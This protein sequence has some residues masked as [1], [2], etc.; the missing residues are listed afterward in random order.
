MRRVARAILA[1]LPFGMTGGM[2]AAFL[3]YF[4][5]AAPLVE[6]SAAQINAQ[7]TRAMAREVTL[8]WLLPR[9]ENAKMEQ[10]LIQMDVLLGLARDHGVDLPDTMQ[11]EIAEMKEP[12]SGLFARAMACGVCAL[13]ITQCT[14]LRQIGSCALPFEMTP[15]GDVN[16]LRRAGL[17]YA[18]GDT[19][20]NWDA[21]LALVGLGATGTIMVTGGTSGPVKIGTTLLRSARRIGSLTPAFTRNLGDM[22]RIPVEWSRLHAFIAG[23]AP[24]ED[25]TDVAR[26]APLQAVAADL[27]RIRRNTSTAEAL[28][29]MRYVDS[30]AEAAGLAR[31]SDALGP[32]TRSAFEV[33]GKSRVLRAT[34][35]LSDLAIAAALAIYAFVLHIVLAAAQFCGNLCLRAVRHGLMR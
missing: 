21:G 9:L 2:V 1:V 22:L 12:A 8:D 29:L 30:P 27:G 33:L 5:F 18:R 3:A 32:K 11:D 6:Q 4:P 35:R 34:V 24:L 17:A 10:D 26:L 20:D 19:V 14:T 7:I 13:D 28:V 16:A 15:A 31:V 25:V 23:R